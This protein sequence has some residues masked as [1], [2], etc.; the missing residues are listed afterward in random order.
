M[1]VPTKVLAEQQAR[2]A[3]STGIRALAINED[4][5]R[6]AQSQS[7]DLFAEILSGSDIRL[8]VMSP[9]MLRSTRMLKLLQSPSFLVLV[10]WFLVDEAHLVDDI[11]EVESVREFLQELA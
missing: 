6:E 5:V 4:T 8:A 2:V 1:I 11:S 10:R 9:Q 3:S 7:R